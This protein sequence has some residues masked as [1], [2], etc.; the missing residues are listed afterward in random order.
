MPFLS[1]QDVI[2]QFDHVDDPDVLEKAKV[3]LA[4]ARALEMSM[5]ENWPGTGLTPEQI[6][7]GGRNP[8]RVGAADN[9]VAG[10]RCCTDRQQA[11]RVAVPPGCNPWPVPNARRPVRGP[12]DRERAN[13]H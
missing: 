10:P 9:C 2:D 6:G 5:Q 1:F 13:T 4:L 7:N 12:M 8:G 3:N 11:H